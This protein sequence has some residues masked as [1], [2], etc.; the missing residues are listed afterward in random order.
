MAL[1]VCLFDYIP[2]DVDRM[3]FYIS[4]LFALFS[5][6][7]N[8]KNG[9]VVLD[10]LAGWMGR[11]GTAIGFGMAGWLVG[12]WRFDIPPRACLYSSFPLFSLSSSFFSRYSYRV[13]VV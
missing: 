3:R 5:D 6:V 13:L 7:E 4:L 9:G 11:V 2:I 1:C 8:E 12:L 10:G